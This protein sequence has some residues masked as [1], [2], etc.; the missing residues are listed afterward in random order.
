[1]TLKT[2]FRPFM[3][4]KFVEMTE[5]L[6][7]PGFRRRFGVETRCW[8]ASGRAVRQLQAQKSGPQ[9]AIAPG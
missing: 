7:V 4:F 1:M 9:A 5:V 6:A 2:I 8:M 3:V